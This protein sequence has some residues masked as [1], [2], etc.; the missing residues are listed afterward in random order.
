MYYPLSHELLMSKFAV[1]STNNSSRHFNHNEERI[2]EY[3]HGQAKWHN[4][5]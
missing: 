3:A 4:C 1:I 2:V 5:L